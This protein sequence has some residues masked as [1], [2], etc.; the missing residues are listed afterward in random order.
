MAP[1]LKLFAGSATASEHK[2]FFWARL[3][4]TAIYVVILGV[5]LGGFSVTLYQSLERNLMDASDDTFAGIEFHHQFVQ[6]TLSSVR[7]EIFLIDIIILLA[8]AGMSYVVAGY[9]LRPIQQALEAQKKFSENASHELRTPLAVMKN[10]IEVLLRHPNPSKESV[11]ETLHSTLEEIDR[12]TH[13][14]KDLLILARSERSGAPALE[15]V[16]VTDIAERMADKMRPLAARKDVTIVTEGEAPPV[17]GSK[18]ALEHVFLNLLQNAIEHTPSGGKITMHMSQDRSDAVVRVADTGSGIAQ[19]DLPHLFERFY[20]GESA[21]GTGL[22]L[23]IVKE[24][25]D[26]HGGSIDIASAQGE[27]TTATIRL[28]AV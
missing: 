18:T 9:T 5:I 26:Q 6:T 2:V 21:A 24:L 7:N 16:A 12:M 11:R 27:G 19:K 25:I 1:L 15:T 3:K 17:R 22:G 8:A 23:S 13:M 14:A 20:K 10:D 4:L 28:K